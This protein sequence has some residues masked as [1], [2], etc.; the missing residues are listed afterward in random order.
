[1]WE[2]YLQ[3]CELGFHYQSLCVFQVQLAKKIG[4]VPVTRDYMYD[5]QDARPA[6]VAAE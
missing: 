5:R 4:A 3:V 2:Y 6:Q 1:M